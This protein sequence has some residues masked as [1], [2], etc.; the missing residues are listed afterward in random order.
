MKAQPIWV[1]VVLVLCGQFAIAQ[2]KQTPQ[3]VKLRGCPMAGVEHGCIVI[4]SKGQTYD[5]SGATPKPDPKKHLMISLE[6]TPASGK[7]SYCMQGPILTDITWQYLKQSC[8][9]P[10]K[11]QH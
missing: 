4:K 11:D 9:V 7:V 8:P 3:R 6:G 5:I 1:A 10:K 2:D